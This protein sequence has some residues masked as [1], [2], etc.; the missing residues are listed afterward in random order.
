LPRVKIDVGDQD[1]I[2]RFTQNLLTVLD[3]NKVP[4]TLHIGSGTHN[5]AFW[6][7]LMEPYLLWFAEAWRED[8]KD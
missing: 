1:A 7:P 3:Q 2:S 6:S 5:W 8:S 4:Y